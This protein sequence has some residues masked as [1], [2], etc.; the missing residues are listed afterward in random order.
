MDEGNQVSGDAE[1]WPTIEEIR[2]AQEEAEEDSLEAINLELRDGLLTDSDNRIFIPAAPEHL[3]VR[4]M[5]VAH[6]GAAGPGQTVMLRDL[7]RRFIWPDM[8]A[9][10]RDFV[11][12]CLLCCKTRDGTVVPPPVGKALRG[13]EPGVSLHLDYIT[14]FE[15]EGLLVLKDGFSGFVL[16]T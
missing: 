2:E 9:Q 6:A 3:R 7:Q 13:A 16:L 11:R 8:A 14:M 5:V 15:G 10:V 12:R 1:R 4:L